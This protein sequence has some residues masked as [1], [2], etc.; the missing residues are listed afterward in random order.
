MALTDE[1]QKAMKAFKKKLKHYR[2]D[3]ESR[4]GGP[5][6]GGRTSDIQGIEPP[7][8]FRPAIWDELVV[9]GRLKK[10]DRGMYSIIQQAQ[11]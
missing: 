9:A 2:L 6:T 5:L 3:D 4:L 1:Q 7:G 10:E 11:Q 8:G